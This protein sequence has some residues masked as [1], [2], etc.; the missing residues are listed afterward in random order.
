[1]GS[2]STGTGNE[3]WQ[4]SLAFYASVPWHTQHLHQILIWIRGFRLSSLLS[5]MSWRQWSITVLWFSIVLSVV[6]QTSPVTVTQCS[7]SGF[8]WVS[9][10][11]LLHF[12][13]S[14]R[15]W[16]SCDE[17]QAINSKSQTPCLVAAYLESACGERT[18]SLQFFSS[19][20]RITLYLATNIP[21]VPLG[22]HYLGPTASEANLCRCSSVTYSAISACAGCQNRAYVSWL[23]WNQDCTEVFLTM[24]EFIHLNSMIIIS[25]FTFSP[26][27]LPM[28]LFHLLL[29]SPAGPI[30]T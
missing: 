16:F 21:E 20:Y 19:E 1:M 8:D 30:S 28:N 5:T 23:T 14:D 22:N 3:H 12:I 6:G 10:F 26:D 17:W 29:W 27:F 13:S 11:R 18:F 4:C 7:S 25:P 15:L 2:C 24:L 9:S